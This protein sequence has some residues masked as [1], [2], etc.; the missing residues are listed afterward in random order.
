MKTPEELIQK[1]FNDG[2]L[3]A[4]YQPELAVKLAQ[5]Q[6]PQSPYYTGL[7][8]GKAEYEAEVNAWAKG[9]SRGTQERDD[10]EM[11]KER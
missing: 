9:F 8:S 6:N 2:Y 1:G 5:Q 4:K 3:L 7:V 10:R 11:D